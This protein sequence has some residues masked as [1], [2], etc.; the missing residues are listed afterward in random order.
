MFFHCPPDKATCMVNIWFYSTAYL[1]ASPCWNLYLKIKPT[2]CGVFFIYYV[3]EYIVYIKK[4]W[5]IV[6]HNLRQKM[7]FN[8]NFL[9]KALF[10]FN[11]PQVRLDVCCSRDH[12]YDVC[13]PEQCLIIDLVN[14]AVAWKLNETSLIFVGSSVGRR[15]KETHWSHCRQE[16][17]CEWFIQCWINF[18]LTS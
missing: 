13:V 6:S 9:I 1:I 2:T 12:E 7:T 18:T 8:G 14:T 11:W 3:A 4:I 15:G 10:H 16:E 5:Q 17:L